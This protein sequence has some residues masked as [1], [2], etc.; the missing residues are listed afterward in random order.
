LFAETTER[1][2]SVPPKIRELIRDLEK[3]GFV[4][5][6]GKGSHRKFVHPRVQKPVVISGNTGDDALDYQQKAVHRAIQESQK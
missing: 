2:W 6:G 4:N 5:R 1:H 3:A